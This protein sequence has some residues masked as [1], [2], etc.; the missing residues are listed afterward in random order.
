VR[1]DPLIEYGQERR[2]LTA[3]VAAATAQGLHVLAATLQ[4][5]LDGRVAALIPERE[6]M[7]DTDRV[8]VR[9]VSGDVHEMGDA[10]ARGASPTGWRGLLGADMPIA[11]MGSG[12]LED[13][14]A[15]GYPREIVLTTAAHK[16][17]SVDMFT[18]EQKRLAV[19]ATIVQG[20][21]RW[22]PGLNR[23]LSD[24]GSASTGPAVV[25]P[26]T[27][28]AVKYSTGAIADGGGSAYHAGTNRIYYMRSNP[29][30]LASWAPDGS[31][32]LLEPVTG[33]AVSN[34]APF[35]AVVTSAGL[36]VWMGQAAGPSA[37]AIDPA[38]A[39][40][41]WTYGA[42]GASQLYTYST[43]DYCPAADTIWVPHISAGLSVLNAQTGALIEQ[44]A[45]NCHAVRYY[46]KE[47]WMMAVS[48]AVPNEFR[49]YDATTRQLIARI[50][51]TATWKYGFVNGRIILPSSSI[52]L[53]QILR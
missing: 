51:N 5:D 39:A 11:A 17:Y 1:L 42:A 48:H 9:D 27:L 40:T 41:A 4:A 46:P 47:N 49:L 8:L 29:L 24:T 21:L 50:L 25:D 12:F 6:S 38:N 2:S 44:I 19:G 22:W 3:Q 7:L 16:A 13:G 36:I 33:A 45:F 43:L 52:I 30:R 37:Y 28:E 23:F 20:P 53:R 26:V 10:I 34:G 32:Y 15:S 35:G 18:G 14:G 31:G